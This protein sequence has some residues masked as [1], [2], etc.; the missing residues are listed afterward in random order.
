MQD[1]VVK[2]LRELYQMMGLSVD[3]FDTTSGFTVHFLQNSFKE[4]PFKSIPFRPNYFSFLFVKEAVGKYTIDDLN[5]NI[6]AGTVYFTNPG[7]HRIF[8]W[9]KIVDAC[10]ITFSESYLKEY[11]HDDVYNEFPYLLTETVEP[12]VLIPKN[13][14]AIEKLYLQIYGE[15]QE[16]S[17][18]KHKIIGSLTVA[19]LL[20]IKE[21]FFTD[22]NPIYEGN[23][24]SQIVRTFKL[25]LE[26]HFRELVSG[27]RDKLLRVQDFAEMQLL[28]ANY[29]SSVIAN[30]TGK[31]ISTWI[32]EKVV[33]EAKVL[34]QQ[35]NL[36]IKEIAV[37]LGFLEPAHFSNHFKKHTSVS[38]A[39]YRKQYFHQ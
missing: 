34:L 27:K 20:K 21:Y 39:E 4:L 15:Y 5:F 36:S 35:A 23:R 22:Y 17:P 33:T 6:E 14:E 38:P 26:N 37:R 11:V 29:L 24:S 12:R 30:K 1:S 18:F 7:N 2:D 13:F 16:H 25:N 3:S 8:E 10:L 28:H 31:S 19:L 32:A 9:H